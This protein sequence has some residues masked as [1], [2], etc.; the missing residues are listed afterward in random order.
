MDE[1]PDLSWGAWGGA[2]ALLALLAVALLLDGLL[3]GLL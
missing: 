1:A 3:D 2:L